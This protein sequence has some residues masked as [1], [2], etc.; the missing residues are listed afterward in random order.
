MRISTTEGGLSGGLIKFFILAETSSS[1]YKSIFI[2]KAQGGMLDE[3]SNK[4]VRG[5]EVKKFKDEFEKIMSTII[6]DFEWIRSTTKIYQQ[7]CREVNRMKFSKA[8]QKIIILYSD[9]LENSKLFSFFYKNDKIANTKNDLNEVKR[10][11]ESDS[12]IQKAY[13]N[14]LSIDCEFPD[15]SD[16]EFY[17]VSNRNVAYDEKINLAEKFWTSLFRLKNAKR[18]HYG[19]ELRFYD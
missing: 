16:I 10:W 17:I 4:Y 5:E 8:D 9:M 12:N 7:L 19:A 14:I 11:I 13:E 3:K 6:T 1:P 2:E 15:L 18:V